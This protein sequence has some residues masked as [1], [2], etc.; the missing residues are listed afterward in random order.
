MPSISANAVLGDPYSTDVMT[1]GDNQDSLWGFVESGNDVHNRGEDKDEDSL[2]V[3]SRTSSPFN[4]DFRSLR[5]PSPPPLDILWPPTLPWMKFQTL[6]LGRPMSHPPHRILRHDGLAILRTALESQETAVHDNN[7]RSSYPAPLSTTALVTVMGSR[8]VIN[9]V[10]TSRDL[11]RAA[12]EIGKSVPETYEGEHAAGLQAML[13]GNTQEAKL[14]AFR[15]LVY[16]VSNNLIEHDDDDDDSDSK[17]QR[18]VDLFREIGLPRDTWE[19]NFAKKQDYS[20][21][22]FAEKVFEAA[23]NACDLEV[24]ESLLKSG[25]NPNQPIMSYMNGFS[26][27][28]I[29]IATDN[30]VQNVAMA[31]LLIRAGAKVDLTTADNERP[32]LHNSAQKGTLEMVQLL[33]ENGGDIYREYGGGPGAWELNKP[34]LC[35]AA[36]TWR[37]NLDGNKRTSKSAH[38][39]A[40]GETEG[41][42]ARI[43]R[44]LASLHQK[45]RTSS[46]DQQIIQRALLT[47]ASQSDLSLLTIL[48]QAGADVARAGGNGITPLMVAACHWD[49]DTRVANYLLDHG[50]TVD[51]PA[52]WP[53]ALH[54][55]AVRGHRKMVAMLIGRG[56]DVNLWGRIDT[57]L[58]GRSML[59][60][61][62]NPPCRGTKLSC[63]PLQLSLHR[64]EEPSTPI[65]KSN[66]P[67]EAAVALLEAGAELVGGELV[68]AARFLSRR[69]VGA[70]LERGARPDEEDGNGC[71]ALQMALKTY[72]LRGDEGEIISD[73]LVDAGATVRKGDIHLAFSA[74]DVQL[75]R[76]LVNKGDLQ[77]TGRPGESLLEAAL[78]SRSRLMIDMALTSTKFAYSP[79]ALCAGVVALANGSL[80]RI[81]ALLEKRRH[82]GAPIYSVSVL[83]ATAVSMAAFYSAA[84]YS[85]NKQLTTLR[86]LLRSG[87]RGHPCLLPYKDEYH[88][89]TAVI[90]RHGIRSLTEKYNEPGWWRKAD[91]IRCSPLAPVFFTPNPGRRVVTRMLL[92]AGYRPDSLTLLM[93]IWLATPDEVE[94][95]IRH[96]ADVNL[97]RHN[98]DTPLQLAVRRGNIDIIHHLLNHQADVNALPAVLVPMSEP[99]GEP[100]EFRPRSA[101]AMAVEKGQLDVIDLLLKAGADVNGPIS[102]D[103]GASALQCAAAKGFL[104]IANT[105][106]DT[107]AEVNAARAGRYGRTALEAAA[108]AGRLDMVQFLLEKGVRTEGDGEGLWQYLRAVGFAERHGHAVVAAL[109]GEWRVL[110]GW[111]RGCAG[112]WG[113]LDEVFVMPDDDVLDEVCGSYDCYDSD[114]YEDRETDEGSESGGSGTDDGRFDSEI[115]TEE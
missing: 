36:A 55:A 44:Y 93:A 52:P 98:L 63:T 24:L 105:L 23:V 100:N 89:Y 42:G 75:A 29:Q 53:S 73:I 28:P 71:T 76:L 82:E 2:V 77:D 60:D 12:A 78:L 62:F 95:L 64:T 87:L 8:D 85:P 33:A 50:A 5:T 80:P 68:Q 58:H 91:L 97:S 111:E 10:A 61:D 59:G 25:V 15:M 4:V 20:S 6:Y 49:G 46:R 66:K 41:R 107:G 96:G 69:L 40:V 19:E 112:Y 13:A 11:D 47:A 84:K 67:D 31:R 3:V 7:E 39:T 27:R 17:Y 90:H 108:E 30:R 56:A 9:A 92:A 88:S 48:H 14:T 79:G 104:G 45:G 51:E 37:S 38:P 115:M 54:F 114:D 32:A 101:L 74:G 57:S 99:N 22:A 18:I 106:I 86:K 34:P 26:E 70:L 43:L 102:T 16:Q 113:L 35:Y 103:G 72:H 1:L 94:D 21:K 83:E 81:E 110:D 109:L 65:W